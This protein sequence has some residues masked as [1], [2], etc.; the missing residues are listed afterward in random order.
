MIK[1]GCKV[2]WDLHIIPSKMHH[3]TPVIIIKIY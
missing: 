1:A 2:V 3:K